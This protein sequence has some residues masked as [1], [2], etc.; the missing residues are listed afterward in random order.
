MQ[1]S[2][3]DQEQRRQG[4]AEDQEQRREGVA[5]DQEQRRQG[6]AGDKETA[7]DRSA[8]TV[9]ERVREG[10]HFSE[11]IARDAGYD[12][13]LGAVAQLGP[14]YAFDRG[15]RPAAVDAVRQALPVMERDLFDAVLEDYACELAATQEA[16]LRVALAYGRRCRTSE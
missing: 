10:T 4:V 2:H 13:L 9:A 15:G 16:L 8:A 12:Q 6:V 1:P 11:A 5:G 14:T 7:I 3:P